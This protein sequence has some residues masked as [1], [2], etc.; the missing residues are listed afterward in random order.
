MK[1][2]LIWRVHVQRIADRQ[3]QFH[4]FYSPSRFKVAEHVIV[5][6]EFVATHEYSP[7]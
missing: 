2:K 5:P 7:S 1:E 4:R 6:A 3:R